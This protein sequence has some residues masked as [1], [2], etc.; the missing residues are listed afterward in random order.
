MYGPLYAPP[1]DDADVTLIVDRQ[2]LPT[3]NINEIIN[4]V[5][6]IRKYCI[7]YPILRMLN[8]VASGKGGNE[9]P[10]IMRTVPDEPIFILSRVDRVSIIFHLRFDEPTDRAIARIVVQELTE[11]NRV[12]N[13]APVC[14]WS[15]REPPLELKGIPNIP[16]PNQ[17]PFS[18]GYLT[19]SIFPNSCKTDNQKEIIA[20]Q[21]SLFR[22]YLLYHIKAGKAYLHARMRNRCDSLQRV[23]NRAIPED[24]FAEKEKKL[25]SGK[26]FVRK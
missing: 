6:N 17:D 8:I 23:L 25:A 15:E 9:K 20:G 7:S 21:F 4:K 24:P 19:F 3:S 13:N 12:V 11:A 26:T 18:I 2:N 1:Y 22:N 16:I 10:F 14:S 5:A